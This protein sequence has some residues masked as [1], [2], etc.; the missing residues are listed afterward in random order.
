M[1]DKATGEVEAVNRVAVDDEHDT[2]WTTNTRNKWVAVDNQR[3]CKHVGTSPGTC[4]ARDIGL[5]KHHHLH[6]AKEIADGSMLD[7]HTLTCKEKQQIT[8]E[9]AQA[10]LIT[11][12]THICNIDSNETTNDAT[13]TTSQDKSHRRFINKT[14][15]HKGNKRTADGMSPETANQAPDTFGFYHKSK[16][17]R[18][19]TITTR[20][21]RMM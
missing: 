20:A 18:T 4:H 2:V 9:G 3:T 13:S 11:I 12:H 17:N 5:D 15:V 8:A 21:D 14:H 6:P 7:F 19:R 16:P 1:T 10:A